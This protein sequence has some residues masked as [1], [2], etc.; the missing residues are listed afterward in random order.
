MRS[1]NIAFNPLRV[2]NSVLQH[3]RNLFS[4]INESGPMKPYYY[5]RFRWFKGIDLKE[6][7]RELKTKFSV[8]EIY[9]PEKGFFDVDEFP[10]SE[11][12][13]V[14]A[15]ADTLTTRLSPFRAVLFQGK[16]EPFTERDMELRNRIRELYPRPSPTIGYKREP[17]F[18]VKCQKIEEPAR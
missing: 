10:F 1:D 12:E 7:A 6:V 5:V 17:P 18:L 13:R 3:V 16:L 14:R 2:F 8:E 11:R 4:K 9:M 15:K